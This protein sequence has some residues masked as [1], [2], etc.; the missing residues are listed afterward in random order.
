MRVLRGRNVILFPDIDGYGLWRDKAK[1]LRDFC[2]TIKIS[3]V[4]ERYGTDG[5]RER[6]VDIADILLRD[7]PRI[8]SPGEEAK[9][10]RGTDAPAVQTAIPS[11]AGILTAKN[12]ELGRLIEELGLTLI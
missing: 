1:I 3:E 6:Q 12:P 11:K 9:T 8:R 4:L 7:L 5:D 10:E 2:K